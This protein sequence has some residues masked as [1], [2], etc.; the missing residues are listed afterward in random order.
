MQTPMNTPHRLN[1]WLISRCHLRTV[2]SQGFTLL[3]LLVVMVIVGILSAVAIP[4]LLNQV[5]RARITEAFT[6]MNGVIKGQY[7]RE[8]DEGEYLQVN[9]VQNGNQFNRVADGDSVGIVPA[10]AAGDLETL[11]SELDVE[12]DPTF[13]QRWNF[14][15]RA[16]FT[17]PPRI[18]LAVVGRDD[19]NRTRRLGIYFDG[20]VSSEFAVDFEQGF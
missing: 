20:V 6:F 12:V 13:D 19:N 5:R 8:L 14:G 9:D 3:E 18:K 2:P 17:N 1:L 10:N 16:T 15:T 4:S 7:I 11:I